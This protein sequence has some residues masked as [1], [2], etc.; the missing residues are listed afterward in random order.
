MV[1]LLSTTFS[2]GRVVVVDKNAAV[3][4]RLMALLDQDVDDSYSA[5]DEP[6]RIVVESEIWASTSRRRGAGSC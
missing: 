5:S 1:S 2:G 4:T 6:I 3:A